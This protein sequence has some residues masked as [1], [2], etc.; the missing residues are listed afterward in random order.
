MDDSA[1]EVAAM[2][3]AGGMAIAQIAEHWERDA[4]WVEEAIRQ[5]LLKSIPKRDGGL[6]APRAEMRGVRSEEIEALREVQQKLKW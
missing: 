3:F 1:R 2:Q 5:A 4:S 6:K